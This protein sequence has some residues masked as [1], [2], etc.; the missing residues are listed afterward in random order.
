MSITQN[1]GGSPTQVRSF[2]YE[3]S[4]TGR[5]LTAFT[6]EAGTTT[7]TYDTD[8]VCGA[9]TGAIVKTA[10]NGG[11]STCL[12]YDLLH[13]LTLKTYNGLNSAV[14][15]SRTFVYDSSASNAGITCPS[16]GGNQLG[17]LAEVSTGT[18]GVFGLTEEGF[19]YEVGGKR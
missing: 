10:D 12:Q 4:N 19:C 3:N 14:T 15:P 2:T 13:R 11:G 9:F 8:T 7:V 6:P 5:M 17:R 16:G 18:A 1:S